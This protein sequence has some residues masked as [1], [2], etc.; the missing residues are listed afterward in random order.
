[1]RTSLSPKSL[2][3]VAVAAVTS[4]AIVG[5]LL[6]SIPPVVGLGDKVKLP[7]FMVGRRGSI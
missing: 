4:A 1:M 3:F 2:G 6:M 5:G 7:L